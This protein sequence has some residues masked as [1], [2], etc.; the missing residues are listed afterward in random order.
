MATPK[1]TKKAKTAR[2]AM[3]PELKAAYRELEGS[4]KN[5]GKL[6][7]DVRHGLRSAERAIQTDARTRIKALREDARTHLKALESQRGEV[8][9]TLG[10]LR[11]AAEG[12]W[13]DL[14][15]S[16]ETAVA[17]ART[18]AASVMERLRRAL[19]H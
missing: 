8:S 17:S 1:R 16:A 6:I 10:R 5:V 9:R 14:R 12:S 3:S 15:Q 13:S 18:T 4:V 11:K 7:A 2:P 19:G